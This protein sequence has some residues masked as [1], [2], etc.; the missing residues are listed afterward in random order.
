MRNSINT[1]ALG[2]V[3]DSDFSMR[4]IAQTNRVFNYEENKWED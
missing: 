4:E 3:T 1:K 2:I